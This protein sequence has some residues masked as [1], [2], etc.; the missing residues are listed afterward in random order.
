VHLTVSRN[1]SWTSCCSKTVPQTIT[2]TQ[3]NEVPGSHSR[4]GWE[5][6]LSKMAPEE[7]RYQSGFAFSISIPSGKRWKALNQT[8]FVRACRALVDDPH[9]LSTMKSVQNPLFRLRLV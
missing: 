5:L 1:S 4:S 8:K 6:Q 7:R 9:I 3:S 2:W